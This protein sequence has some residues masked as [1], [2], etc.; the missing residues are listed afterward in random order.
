M[1]D[2]QL[3]KEFLELNITQT[4]FA[5]QKGIKIPSMNKKLW[6]QLNMLYMMGLHTPGPYAYEVRYARKNKEELLKAIS[7]FTQDLE[8]TDF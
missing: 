1:T 2:F 5:K 8:Q 7:N 6:Y 4:E 3:L